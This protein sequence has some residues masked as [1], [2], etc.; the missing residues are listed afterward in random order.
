M[1]KRIT[2]LLNIRRYITGALDSN[3]SVAGLRSALLAW[4]D[5]IDTAIA[6]E[7]QRA[8]TE[9]TGSVED[10]GAGRRHRPKTPSVTPLRKAK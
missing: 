6:T 4:A 7:T 2:A 3:L 9:N 8:E 1:D 5:E 10:E